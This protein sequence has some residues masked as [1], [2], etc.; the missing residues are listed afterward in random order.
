MSGAHV[1]GTTSV[2]DGA[3]RGGQGGALSS[4]SHT[5]SWGEIGYIIQYR[6]YTVYTH[7]NSGLVH[8]EIS[9]AEDCTHMYSTG[10]G[11]NSILSANYKLAADLNN[12]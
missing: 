5:H 8:T 2:K 9:S 11:S 3:V 4:G 7:W 6:L 12:C 10:T 1:R